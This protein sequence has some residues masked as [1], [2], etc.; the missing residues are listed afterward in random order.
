M[1][2]SVQ[3]P[4]EAEHGRAA[5]R[6]VPHRMTGS[7]HGQ[8]TQHLSRNGCDDSSVDRQ[9]ASLQIRIYNANGNASFHLHRVMAGHPV[10]RR[11]NCFGSS[12]E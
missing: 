1:Y 11:G 2:T 7:L 9:D 10:Q 8:P 5:E 3:G 12:F 4:R 6:E